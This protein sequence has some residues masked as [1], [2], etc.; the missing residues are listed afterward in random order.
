MKELFT[1]QLMR[2]GDF[3][4]NIFLVK[5]L[6][7]KFRPVF[8]L[9]K[10]NEFV[11]YEHF[12]QKTFPFV[13][14]L[15]Q[16][17]V[18]FTSLDLKAACFSIPIHSSYQKFLKFFLESQFISIQTSS[19]WAPYVFT[20][21][22]KPV[23]TFFRRYG[24]R[25]SYYLDDSLNMNQ[26]KDMCCQNA[27]FMYSHIENLGFVINKDKSVLVPTQRIAFFGFIIDSVLFMVFMP[28]EKIKK[29]LS[30][31]QS[32][33]KLGRLELREVESLIDR[34]INAFNAVLEAPLHIEL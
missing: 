15:I 25:C 26:N 24:I 16:K 19:F 31:A 22:M 2:V 21:V 13:L 28:A 7:G 32:L 34:I 23:F 33:L 17:G 27:C 18:F 29:I 14:E 10:M 6:N 9:K 3:I 4:S 20:N 12:K 5:S 30:L 8:N 1:F 11:H